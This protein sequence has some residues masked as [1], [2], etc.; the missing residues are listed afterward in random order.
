MWWKSG[1]PE[2]IMDLKQILFGSCRIDLKCAWNFLSCHDG[3]S[4]NVTFLLVASAHKCLLLVCASKFA[5]PGRQWRE[6][7]PPLEGKW[8]RFLWSRHWCIHWALH[9]W[10]I[11]LT[12]VSRRNPPWPWC[13]GPRPFMG[14]YRTRPFRAGISRLLT[15]LFA[16]FLL[17]ANLWELKISN[18]VTA[19]LP[20]TMQ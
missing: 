1:T 3:P 8:Y 15:T 7:E 2:A 6:N 16:S 17:R 14:S 20:F 12:C 18:Q 4:M 11:S 9:M 5:C 13:T 10:G 19:F